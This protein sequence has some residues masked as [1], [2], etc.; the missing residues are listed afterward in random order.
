MSTERTVY[1]VAVRFGAQGERRIVSVLGAN[2]NAT[3]EV[4]WTLAG[5]YALHL[6]RNVMLRSPGSRYPI[7]AWEI[8]DLPWAWR[9]WRA[10]VRP[11]A[12]T[13]LGASAVP[14]ANAYRYGKRTRE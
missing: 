7:G 3:L 9:V 13:V 6:K 8:V 5:T 11:A 2:P 1:G 4:C 10:L 14:I 12:R